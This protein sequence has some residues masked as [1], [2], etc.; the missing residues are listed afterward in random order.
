VRLTTAL[1]ARQTNE[2][3]A[4]KRFTRRATLNFYNAFSAFV[5]VC[6]CVCVCVFQATN[7]KRVKGK[8][9]RT[10]KRGM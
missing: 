9:D 10:V 6:V 4:R 2:I 1:L 3:I 5:R 8:S 7:R